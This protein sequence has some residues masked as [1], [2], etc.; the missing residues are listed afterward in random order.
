[1]LIRFV[2]PYYPNL[3]DP[4][5]YN[6]FNLNRNP[7]FITNPISTE[8]STLVNGVIREQSYSYVTTSLFYIPTTGISNTDFSSRYPDVYHRSP[9]GI[10][11]LEIIPEGLPRYPRWLSQK[12]IRYM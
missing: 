1:L 8:L 4:Y 6:Q 7:F 3:F 10:C 5:Y 9:L 12:S 2:V 11:E